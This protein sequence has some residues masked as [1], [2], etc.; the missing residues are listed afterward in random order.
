[1]FLGQ[2]PYACC[3]QQGEMMNIFFH[4][5]GKSGADLDFPKTVFSNLLISLIEDG[6]SDNYP[7][8]PSLIAALQREFPSGYL[9]CWGVPTGAHLD[10]SRLETGDLV[11]LMRFALGHP[12]LLKLFS[13]DISYY[14]VYVKLPGLV[15]SP[16]RLSAVPDHLPRLLTHFYPP[17]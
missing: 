5:V 10:F 9:N 1:M 4:N 15:Y 11:L 13:P 16:L 6:I 3:S 2:G 12:F 7:E 8:K 14:K 17:S